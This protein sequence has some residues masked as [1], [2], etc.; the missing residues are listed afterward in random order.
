MLAF[1]RSQVQRIPIRGSAWTRLV[2]RL[3]RLA[4]GQG[5]TPHI[6][7]RHSYEYKKWFDAARK[8]IDLPKVLVYYV[9]S[10]LAY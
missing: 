3:S 7:P 4:A 9:T 6:P 5:G 10:T 8:T 2:W 1:L